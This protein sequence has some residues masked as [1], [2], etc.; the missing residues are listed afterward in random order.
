MQNANVIKRLMVCY[1][2]EARR[3]RSQT[4]HYFIHFLHHLQTALPTKEKAGPLFIAG[5]QLCPIFVVTL[6]S[7]IKIAGTCF[8]SPRF[9]KEAN[10][11]LKLGPSRFHKPCE[12]QA[13]WETQER[14]PPQWLTRSI[15][16]C[17]IGS[18]KSS[19]KFNVV[20]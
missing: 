16:P 9:H 13:P 14:V 15:A 7:E 17:S 1:E 8:T 18:D 4:H 3:R 6:T 10:I 5:Q 19:R 20:C 12:A 2:F 11:S